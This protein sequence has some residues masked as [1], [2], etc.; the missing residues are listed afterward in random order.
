MPHWVA[1]GLTSPGPVVVQCLSLSPCLLG[2][3][4]IS[5]FPP[6]VHR[7][8]GDRHPTLGVLTSEWWMISERVEGLS[9]KR[10]WQQ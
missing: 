1:K 4:L 10:G 3:P 6:T 7:H 5:P 8:A 9:G 2:F